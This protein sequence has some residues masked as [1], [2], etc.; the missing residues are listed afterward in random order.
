MEIL[1]ITPRNLHYPE[2]EIFEI[3][4]EDAKARNWRGVR[5]QS[6]AATPLSLD[7]QRTRAAV[8]VHSDKI[9]DSKTIFL[10]NKAAVFMLRHVGKLLIILRKIHQ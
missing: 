1:I 9:I 5:R 7:F 6:E 3:S 4:R 2:A 8:T 10:S